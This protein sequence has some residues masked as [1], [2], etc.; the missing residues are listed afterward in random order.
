MASTITNPVATLALTSTG[1]SFV[2]DIFTGTTLIGRNR[3]D[4]TSSGITIQSQ[5]ASLQPTAQIIINTGPPASIQIITSGNS[6]GLTSNGITIADNFGSRVDMDTTNGLRLTNAGNVAQVQSTGIK[7]TDNFG[8]TLTMDSTNGIKILRG[9]NYVLVAAGGITIADSSNGTVVM[10]T[11]GITITQG[12]ASVKV[13]AA[14]ITI[15]SSNT[16][17]Q[18]VL[19]STSLSI[20]T[21]GQAT[22]WG[23]ITIKSVQ[24]LALF[25]METGTLALGIFKVQL[26]GT[27]VMQMGPS[28]NP[29]VLNVQI[30]GSTCTIAL[31]GVAVL[32]NAQVLGHHVPR[33]STAG[34]PVMDDGEAQFRFDGS[35]MQLL[36]RKGTQVYY[37][38]EA[39]HVAY[40]F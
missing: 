36:F 31:G 30:S 20:N 33:Y 11:N 10:D 1:L 13:A 9:S 24:T 27:Q 16:G 25:A 8:G 34:I 39:G 18:M 7:L 37:W 12:T 2:R 26:D 14:S 15:N 35:F 23:A 5:N 17:H 40:P 4:L 6:I 22:T 19:T 21:V 3:L 38:V 32:Q 29:T 28:S